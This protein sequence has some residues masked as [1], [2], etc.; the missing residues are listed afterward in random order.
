[1]PQY[2]FTVRRSQVEV[3]SPNGTML[4]NDAAAG[5]EPGRILSCERMWLVLILR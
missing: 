2:F 4:P 3:E 5:G 1:M